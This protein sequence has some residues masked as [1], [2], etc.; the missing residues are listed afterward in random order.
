MTWW[1]YLAAATFGL[2]FGSF[3][4]VVICRVPRGESLVDRS[5]CPR[6]GEMIHWYDNVPVLSFV[7]LRG[8]CRRCGESISW[9]YPLVEAATSLLFVLMY[10]W[11]IN[12]VP[13]MLDIQGA[14]DLVPELFIGLVLVSVAV[15]VSATDIVYGIIPTRVAFT[16]NTF[17]LAL[18]LG[19]AFYRQ[20]PVRIASAL[21][22]AVGAAAL[23]FALGALYGRL[24][25]QDREQPRPEEYS[26]GAE[27]EE[28]QGL[29]IG[30][31]K[32]VVLTLVT[33]AVLAGAVVLAFSFYRDDSYRIV[34]S[35]LVA[36]AGG[37]F[38]L[39]LGLLLN[40]LEEDEHE[41]E[42]EDL[43]T[44]MGF[45]DIRLLFFTGLALGFFNWQLVL[46]QLLIGSALGILAALLL[47]RGSK[48]PIA[49]G[50]FLVVG[51]IFALVWGQALLDW[52]FKLSR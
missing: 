41:E 15:V 44:G 13:G 38:F 12:V 49:F 5:R 35:T 34:V 50:P 23:F 33:G 42:A 7:L 52:F 40:A 25:M 43:K 1:Y 16:G 46:P 30:R 31:T 27:Y 11:S 45:G 2:V 14:G 48:E 18:V 29:N 39:S 20:E 21:G 3:F 26:M 32:S 17:M 10:W 24:R 47:G 37:A 8:R 6:C 19:L 9:Q 28:H 36:V 51:A 4:N 22:L